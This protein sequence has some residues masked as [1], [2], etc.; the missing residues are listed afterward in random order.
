MH[1]FIQKVVHSQYVSYPLY[2]PLREREEFSRAILIDLDAIS[3]VDSVFEG[4]PN[5]PGRR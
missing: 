3:G 5:G 2:I 1:V 4:F